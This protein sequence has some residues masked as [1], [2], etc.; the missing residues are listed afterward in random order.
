MPKWIL[1][2]KAESYYADNLFYIFVNLKGG[3][4]RPD[5]YIV[6]SKIVAQYIRSGHREWL[7]AP[8]KKG[9][10]HRDSAIRNFRDPERHYLDKW[11]LL[12]I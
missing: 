7:K 2:E 9:Q 5:Y 10:R 3:H 1:S 12:A 4:E 11:E 6:P 8:G